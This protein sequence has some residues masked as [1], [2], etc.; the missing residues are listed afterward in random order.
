MR[1]SLL[2]ERSPEGFQDLLK[3]SRVRS[4]SMRTSELQSDFPDELGKVATLAFSIWHSSER[5]LVQ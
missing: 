4:M 1:K 3:R 2:T 5:R